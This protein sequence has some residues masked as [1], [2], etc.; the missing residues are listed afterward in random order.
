MTLL[1]LLLWK[2]STRGPLR[3]LVVV[4]AVS[5]GS[6]ASAQSLADEWWTP[7][8]AARV[9]LAS[10]GESICGTIVWAWDDTPAG[11]SDKRPL[12][13]QRIISGMKA[14]P[15]TGDRTTIYVGAIYNPEDGQTYKASMR[16][17]TANILLVEGCLLFICRE[18]VWRR[19]DSLR[20]P[21]VSAGLWVPGSHFHR[22]TL[23]GPP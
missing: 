11:A 7:G 1:E 17:K 8:F 19:H 23:Q 18:Q 6:L 21:P 5:M 12:V 10:C 13:G 22:L 15:G 9:K 14:Q 20:T 16:L 3:W 2:A 4:M